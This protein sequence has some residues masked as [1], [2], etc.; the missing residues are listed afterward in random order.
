M[1]ESTGGGGGGGGFSFGAEG[2]GV[3]KEIEQM[4]EALEV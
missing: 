2:G 3:K 1:P 4:A